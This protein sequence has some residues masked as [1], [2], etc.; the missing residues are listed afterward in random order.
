MIRNSNAYMIPLVIALSGAGLITSSA[1]STAKPAAQIR[2]MTDEWRS[3]AIAGEKA[4]RQDRFDYSTRMW[5]RAYEV[6]EKLGP[7]HPFL[8]ISLRNLSALY[9]GARRNLDKA[10]P[11]LLRSVQ[12]LNPLGET[13]PDLAEDYYCLG[14]IACMRG[15]FDQA[16]VWY[17]KAEKICQV[18]PP[19]DDMLPDLYCGFATIYRA[20]GDAKK[21]SQYLDKIDQLERLR[22][23]KAKALVYRRLTGWLETDGKFLPRSKDNPFN[24]IAI[25]LYRKEIEL[26][27]EQNPGDERLGEAYQ[28]C[29]MIRMSLSDDQGALDDLTRAIKIF[30]L[31]ERK[32]ETVT[33]LMTY[34][35]R[36]L[37]RLKRP[38]EALS[39]YSAVMNRAKG[40]DNS[41][42]LADKAECCVALGKYDEALAAYQKLIDNSSIPV[43]RIPYQIAMA[44]CLRLQ[45]RQASA[46][47]LL[48]ELKETCRKSITS[49]SDIH[50]Y[51][52]L[53][54]Q[55]AKL[56]LVQESLN[57]NQRARILAKSNYDTLSPQYASSLNTIGN[58]LV[59]P[60]KQYEESCK[61]F[62][63]VIQLTQKNP[64]KTA[65][66][67]AQALA[68]LAE[69]RF[70]LGDSNEAQRL[71]EQALELFE[72]MPHTQPVEIANLLGIQ[73]ELAQKRGDN[74][75]AAT[76]M[77]RRQDALKVENRR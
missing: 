2:A 43:E 25:N 5:T 17:E 58:W 3:L 7:D 52:Q 32:Y 29:A 37:F 15:K 1:H 62:Q 71:S 6:A 68:G 70:R 35:G 69:A 57:C 74:Q 18:Q 40:G 13:Y 23:S 50:F 77:K 45:G 44:N 39:V 72:T 55:F 54:E 14:R 51:F 67:R 20:F 24:T 38:A 11:L 73:G 34:Q 64:K 36:Y 22:S 47:E 75:A 61:Y 26:L 48:T 8:S 66:A 46:I 30:S 31:D 41:R 16:L 10:E 42:W 21:E 28:Q 63:E 76:L 59:E 49:A 4:R 56:G 65:S 9:F 12:I 19:H 33:S 60:L 53:S 27:Q